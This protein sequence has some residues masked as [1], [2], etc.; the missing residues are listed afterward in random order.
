M[1]HLFRPIEEKSFR[2]EFAVHYV[3]VKSRFIQEGHD[4]MDCETGKPQVLMFECAQDKEVPIYN[5]LFG[6]LGT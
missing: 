5:Y 3:S 6:K 1:Q 2:F 4:E